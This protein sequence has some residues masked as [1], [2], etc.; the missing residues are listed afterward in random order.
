MYR[1]IHL[2]DIPRKRF[3]DA[4]K[5]YHDFIEKY[6]RAAEIIEDIYEIPNDFPVM[7]KALRLKRWKIYV[8]CVICW[9]GK[10][11]KRYDKDRE[12]P[13]TLI[14]CLIEFKCHMKVSIFKRYKSL[15]SIDMTYLN[16]KD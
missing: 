14:K 8:Y 3:Y 1:P 11:Q 5:T 12:N 2:S 7:W 10:W 4:L 15:L 16:I 6:S 13:E 9:S